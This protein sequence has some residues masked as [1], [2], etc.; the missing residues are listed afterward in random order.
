[1]LSTRHRYFGKVKTGIN[2]TVLNLYDADSENLKVGIY[3][4]VRLYCHSFLVC[5]VFKHVFKPFLEN[6]QMC[7][8][9]LLVGS[10]TT[11][12]ES[13]N[14]EY[15]QVI[16]QCYKIEPY[17]TCPIFMTKSPNRCH[18]KTFLTERLG[19]VLI[20]ELG[21][22]VNVAYMIYTMDCINT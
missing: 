1:M 4:L 5:Q 13:P 9:M 6:C 22:I 21:M 19:E 16:S 18:I 8:H 14:Q 12:T 17:G 10:P 3:S 11:V 7:L 15:I 2:I 20:L